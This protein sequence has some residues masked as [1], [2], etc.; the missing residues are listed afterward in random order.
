MNSDIVSVCRTGCSRYS[1]KKL[2]LC[3]PSSGARHHVMVTAV[4]GR[5]RRGGVQLAPGLEQVDGIA[6][7][8]RQQ[9]LDAQ[10]RQQL[11]R[12]GRIGQQN[13]HRLVRSRDIHGQQRAQTDGAARIQIGR[14]DRKPALRYDPQSGAHERRPTAF[15]HLVHFDFGRR[16][17]LE[18][19]DENVHRQQ[20]R[21]EFE[22]VEHGVQ[23][24]VPHN[25]IDYSTFL[26]VC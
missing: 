21:H 1:V 18:H 15:E 22:G 3:V 25:S 5:R 14:H 7:Q 9:D 13:G 26:P 17:M 6:D 10:K 19:L 24:N 4:L 8:E 11:D 12:G 16:L 23:Q 2:R 20:Q